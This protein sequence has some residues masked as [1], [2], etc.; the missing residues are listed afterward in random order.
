MIARLWRRYTVTRSMA[1]EFGPTPATRYPELQNYSDAELLARDRDDL[2]AEIEEE[3]AVVAEIR[4]RLANRKET[5][6]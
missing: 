1:A 4:Q 3:R 5:K 2:I 6:R